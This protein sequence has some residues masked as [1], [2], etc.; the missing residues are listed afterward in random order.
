MQATTVVRFGAP[1]YKVNEAFVRAAYT[2]ALPR[3]IKV[4]RN[5]KSTKRVYALYATHAAL[6]SLVHRLDIVI[7]TSS[8][9]PGAGNER[10]G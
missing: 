7:V 1:K 6:H 8:L 3:P 5:P 10:Q 2:D 9:F 4:L